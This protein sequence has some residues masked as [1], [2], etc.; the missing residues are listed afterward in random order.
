LILAGFRFQN[1]VREMTT[2][3]RKREV[4][5]NPFFNVMMATSVV[6]VLTVLAYLVS[7]SVIEPAAGGP[8]QAKSSVA[9]AL[10]LDRNAPLALA[11][12][13]VIMLVTGVVAM[14]TDPFFTTRSRSK[15]PA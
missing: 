13:F 2:R 15:P 4:F 7:P 5:A 3:P 9:F 12:E 10:W 11:V 1:I 6:F 14:A 8:A